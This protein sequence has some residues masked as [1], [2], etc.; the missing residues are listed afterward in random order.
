MNLKR[1]IYKWA[2][3]PVARVMRP[4][5]LGARVAVI[6]QTDQVLLVQHTYS[7][8]WI[9]PGGGVDRGETLR[10]AAFREIREEAGII[11]GSATL[12]GIFSN[13]ANYPGDHVVCY[14]VRRFTREA[15]MPNSEIADARFFPR[16][17]VPADV[18]AGTSRRLAEIFD[19]ADISDFW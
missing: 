4:M 12:H 6:D 18:T 10:A 15:W 13:E 5:T 1:I 8:G 14:V 2:A 11:A 3:R 7:D 16:Q 17:H 19:G 9:L